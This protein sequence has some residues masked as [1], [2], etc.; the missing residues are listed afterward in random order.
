MSAGSVGT[1][2][3]RITLPASSTTHTDVAVTDT[4]RPAKCTISSLLPR[5]IEVLRPQSAIV[6]ERDAHSPYKREP[7][8]PRYT[9]SF[10]ESGHSAPE[11]R[12]SQ[13]GRVEMWRGGGRLGISVS[14]P[15]VWRCLTGAAM[16]PFPHPAHRTGRADFPHPALG[17]GF[18]PSPTA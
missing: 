2:C 13:V 10:Q 6:G 11:A 1:F 15:F 9:I 14:A 18:T 17:Q 4:S 16:A 8:P 7:R 3:S 5:W 12:P